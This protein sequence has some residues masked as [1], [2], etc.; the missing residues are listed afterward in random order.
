MLKNL[1]FKLK[2]IVML[3]ACPGIKVYADRGKIGHFLLP[4]GFVRDAAEGSPGYVNRYKGCLSRIGNEIE[5]S[6]R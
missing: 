2:Q 6:N 3:D 5:N 1:K 4:C